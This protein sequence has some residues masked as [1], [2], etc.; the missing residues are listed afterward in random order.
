MKIP[1]KQILTYVTCPLKLAFAKEE[2]LL[3]ATDLYVDSVKTGIHTY[4]TE[5]GMKKQRVEAAVRAQKSFIAHWEANAAR[6]PLDHESSLLFYQG[7]YLTSRID[8]FYDPRVDEL[9]ATKYP[10]E[11]SMAKDLVLQDTIDVL[12]VR[13]NKSHIVYRAVFLEGPNDFENQ[14]YQSLRSAFFKLALQRH[15]PSKRVTSFL[16]ESRPVIGQ[17]KVICPETHMLKPI[18]TMA[19]GIAKAIKSG[20][21]YPT[22][23]REACKACAY[24]KVCE[25]SLIRDL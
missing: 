13:K 23:N 25:A 4:F 3:T 7:H 18:K 6:I 11:L 24:S 20:A 5:V 14:R 1:F 10:L 8:T 16:Y 2:G 19:I 21:I 22:N 12:F 17:D 15:L 9:V